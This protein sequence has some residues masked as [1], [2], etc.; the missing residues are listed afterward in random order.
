MAGFEPRS[1][2]PALVRTADVQGRSPD[3]PASGAARLA[4][5]SSSTSA[6]R[7]ATASR[8]RSS[9]A[10]S[11]RSGSTR[12]RT[13]AR[14]R[15]PTR[16]RR[17]D[18]DAVRPPRPG[19]GVDPRVA[20]RRHR[21]RGR[22]G[23]PRLPREPHHSRLGDRARPARRAR[24][25]F[26]SARSTSSPGAGGKRLPLPGAWRAL[27]TRLG[28]WLWIGLLGRD[29]RSGGSFPSRLPDPAAAGKPAVTD[30]PV[31]GLVVLGLLVASRVVARPQGARPGDSGRGRRRA[32]RAMPSPSSPSAASPS[33]P[34]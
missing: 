11:R 28:V 3:R 9:A 5:R 25:R 30:W 22:H 16:R 14:V 8:R 34:R 23:G 20:R 7:S 24:S 31:V 13:T 18:P 6:C 29:R 27:R 19:G 10:R 15:S 1:P 33:R 26:S 32:G 12:H 21:A 4:R 2:A 17:L